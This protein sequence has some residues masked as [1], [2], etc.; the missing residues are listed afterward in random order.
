M[1]CARIQVDDES[2]AVARTV[3]LICE[4]VLKQEQMRLW[5]KDVEEG[6]EDLPTFTPRQHTSHTWEKVQRDRQ[7][8]TATEKAWL[9]DVDEEADEI[10]GEEVYNTL[11]EVIH[12]I[13]M[14]E[15][16]S[17]PTE[18]LCVHTPT[19]PLHSPP[20]RDI[21][22]PEDP[23]TFY[24]D[25][26]VVRR[27]FAF[28]HVG[29]ESNLEE[30]QIE[31]PPESDFKPDPQWVISSENH[32]S[33]SPPECCSQCAFGAGT[34]LSREGV[35]DACMW[36][37]PGSEDDVEAEYVCT[38][39]TYPGA[40]CTDCGVSEKFYMA[41][42][43]SRHYAITGEWVHHSTRWTF[44]QSTSVRPGGDNLCPCCAMAVGLLHEDEWIDNVIPN[45]SNED[46]D[47]W[48]S[49]YDEDGTY[50]GEYENEE[51]PEDNSEKMKA[52]KDTVREVGE[53]VFDLQDKLPEG[54]YLKLMD[55]L[56][57]VTNV[58]NS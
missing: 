45:E 51:P 20:P 15:H 40:M 36:R 39:C 2:W 16:W 28:D 6:T 53:F 7:S 42:Q 8:L 35:D 34:V 47:Y 44:I 52:V 33:V 4:E 32:S 14:E 1:A 18:H 13:E 30:G 9:E 24:T 11:S 10:I 31:E 46:G 29:D 50:Y 56:Q 5:M 22:P 54:D 58:A 55:L 48:Q 21:Q 49:V 3:H 27:L 12:Q 37:H 23:P 38:S 19:P 25:R 57:K 17:I 41:C 26:D 43:Q